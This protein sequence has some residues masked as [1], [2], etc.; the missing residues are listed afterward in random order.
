M[1]SPA[2]EALFAKGVFQIGSPISGVN[3]S[4]NISIP[5][6]TAQDL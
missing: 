1:K 5:H 2:S 6:I 4:N 3:F